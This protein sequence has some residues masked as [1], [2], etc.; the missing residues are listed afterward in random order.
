MA[1]VSTA[2]ARCLGKKFPRGAKEVWRFAWER[3]AIVR[4]GLLVFRLEI[5]LESEA[6]SYMVLEECL[7]D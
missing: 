5:L 7:E 2:V 1:K 4:A 6:G 3:P